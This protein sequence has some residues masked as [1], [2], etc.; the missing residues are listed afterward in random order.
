MAAVQG[1]SLLPAVDKEWEKTVAYYDIIS[2]E[3]PRTQASLTWFAV[4]WMLFCSGMLLYKMLK[5]T[6][7]PGSYRHRL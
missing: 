3:M 6:A 1:G 4:F 7:F 2:M 5:R